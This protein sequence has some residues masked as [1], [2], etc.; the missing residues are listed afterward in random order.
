LSS[1]RTFAKETSITHYADSCFLAS[2]GNNR[3]SDLACLE[4]KN[5]VCGIALREDG[6]LLTKHHSF[7]T[8]ADGSEEHS[9]VEVPF[10]PSG[11]G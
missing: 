6:L 4:I 11:G 9:G 3:K 10:A 7:P 8:L 1:Q 5:R 2:F